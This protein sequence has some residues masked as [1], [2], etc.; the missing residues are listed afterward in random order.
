MF[1]LDTDTFKI[2]VLRGRFDYMLKAST[3]DD[4]LKAQR[5]LNRS[6]S[7][8]DKLIVIPFDTNAINHFESLQAVKRLR[9]IGRA[10]LLIASIVLAHKATL[11]TRNMRHFRQIPNLR[12]VNW[13]D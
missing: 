2:E 7:S 11:V 3:S 5:L 4:L 9:K 6:E 12:V 13:V 10:D 1:I 8:L